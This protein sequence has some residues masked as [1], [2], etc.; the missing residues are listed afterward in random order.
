MNPKLPLN[1]RMYMLTVSRVLTT[2]VFQ[3][4]VGQ[5]LFRATNQLWD[6]LSSHGLKWLHATVI[7]SVETYRC[8]N[9][10]ELT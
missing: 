6:G 9:A 1:Q 3:I 7:H 10:S 2:N 4:N 5:I 8:T